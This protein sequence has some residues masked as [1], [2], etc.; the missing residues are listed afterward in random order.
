VSDTLLRCDHEGIREFPRVTIEKYSPDQTAWA[1]RKLFDELSWGRRLL[2][3]RLGVRVPRLHGDWLRQAF[4]EPEDGYASCEGNLMVANGLANMSYLLLGTAAS[5]GNGRPLSL[6]TPTAG[7]GV[8][9]TGGTALVSDTALG[10]NTGSAWYQAM[11]STYPNWA[12]TGVANG[13]QLNGQSTFASGNGNFAW[14]EWCWFTTSAA[15]TGTA[16][17]A[18]AG[19]NATMFNHKIA[20]LGTKGSGASWVFSTTCT[21]S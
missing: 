21:F 19:T 12:G 5:G 18:S 17:L 2:V 8:G 7:V 9:A 13:G 10:A 11:D 4:R 16:T 20:S 15:I 14:N 6:T 1:E 3:A